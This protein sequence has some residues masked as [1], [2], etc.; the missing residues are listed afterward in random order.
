ML[1]WIVAAWLGCSSPEPAPEHEPPGPLPDRVAFAAALARVRPGTSRDDLLALVGEP[2]D[3]RT[4]F[5]PGG[6]PRA[7]SVEVWRYGTDGHLTFPTLGAVHLT[8]AGRVD[9]VFGGRGEA[10]DP[11]VLPEADLRGVLRSIHAVRSCDEGSAFSGVELVRAVNGLHALGR[12]G[13]LAVL[14][15]Y[16]R[17]RQPLDA[18]GGAQVPLI[19][20]GL[21]DAPDGFPGIG[22]RASPAW[23]HGDRPAPRYPIVEQ[24]DV[25]F[26]VVSGYM[27][28]GRRAP[29]ESHLS[30]AAEHGAWRDRR[31]T[32]AD[33]PLEAADRLLV[34]VDD[35]SLRRLVRRQALRMVDTIYRP[36]A[37]SLEGAGWEEHRAEVARLAPGWD[38]QSQR[39]TLPGGSTLPERIDKI[40]RREIWALP[41][42]GPERVL[43]LER[44]DETQ[45]EAQLTATTP[46]G[47]PVSSGRVVIRK[48]DRVLVTLQLPEQPGQTSIESRRFELAPG[49]D[50]VAEIVV[51]EQVAGRRRLSP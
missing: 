41:I 4:L 12:S 8:E 25:P 30:W 19:L 16:L 24:D 10:I 5:D 9:A 1:P 31:L 28:G 49:Q 39:Y 33:D 22:G 13:A 21:F 14:T 20:R 17:I 46:R 51:G 3:K 48:G 44:Q 18:P 29:P 43:V 26:L 35:P 45:V 34:G 38:P 42:E 50:V 6:I 15:E 23:P 36:T 40:Y 47:I 27:L 7:H 11:A 37:P 2:D 32:P